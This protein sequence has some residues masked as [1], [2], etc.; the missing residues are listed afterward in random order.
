MG[1]TAK[2]LRRATSA[3]AGIGLGNTI[4]YLRRT[5]S[6]TACHG[7][8]TMINYSFPPNTYRVLRLR[9]RRGAADNGL[10]TTTKYLRRTTSGAAGNGMRTT[11]KYLRGAAV[12]GLGTT[13]K[14][15]R[16]AASYGLGAKIKYLRRSASDAAGNG[17]CTTTKYLC[18]AGGIGLG[19]TIK[20]LRCTTSVAE[21]NGQ[22]TTIMYLVNQNA[23]ACSNWAE[24]RFTIAGHV[25]SDPPCS[26]SFCRLNPPE[27]DF[28]SKG[29]GVKEF[30]ALSGALLSN[31]SEVAS[32]CWR[33][34]ER[35]LYEK[36]ETKEEE[37]KKH[38]THTGVAAF[39]IRINTHQ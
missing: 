8:G 18:G 38:T 4:K 36:G 26:A 22:G 37:K 17:L 9:Q 1:T 13:A 6:S 33:A 31:Q 35:P 11:A 32:T 25:F 24:V 34:T 16:G 19:T 7:L 2:Y 30:P 28:A 29:S 39:T 12:N 23:G 3:A 15:L 14:Y 5:T 27:P 21:C 20:Y 10:G